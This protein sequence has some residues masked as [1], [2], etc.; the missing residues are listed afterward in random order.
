MRRLRVVYQKGWSLF[1]KRL[2]TLLLLPMASVAQ[3]PL[4]ATNP[5]SYSQRDYEIAKQKMLPMAKEILPGLRKSK[6]CLN[7]AMNQ[8]AFDQCITEMVQLMEK[9]LTEMAQVPG[10]PSR[11]PDQQNQKPRK[12]RYSEHNRANILRSLEASIS[13]FQIMEQCFESSHSTQQMLSC[14]QTSRSSL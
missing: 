4:S 12:L 7:K 9:M 11:V 10:M 8:E 1:M 2:L 3:P 6:G 14:T 5:P 13:R